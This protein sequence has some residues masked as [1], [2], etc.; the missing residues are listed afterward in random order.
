[1]ADTAE[2]LA[3]PP[4]ILGAGWAFGFGLH[5]RFPARLVAGPS[6]LVGGLLAAAGVALIASAVA[7]MRR[8]GTDPRPERPSTVLVTDGPYALSR[9]PIY[10]GLVAIYAG[11]M[12]VVGTAWPVLFLPTGLAVLRTGVVLR[13]E[14]YLAERFG[15]A[16]IDY[17]GRVRR[18]L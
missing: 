15:G 18:W 5:W 4:L 7:S 8:A 2:I 12:L 17:A 3:P 1:L 13:E 9:N 16:F 6:R 11:L 10:L 14:R